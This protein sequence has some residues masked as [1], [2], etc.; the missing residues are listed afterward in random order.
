M[1][2]LPRRVGLARAK[3]LI[4]SGRAVATEEALRIGMVD[5][6]SRAETL[7][8]DAQAWA[9][10]LAQGTSTAIAL[11]KAILNKTYETTDE[12]VFALGSQAQGICYTTR[13]HQEAVAA[14]LN[15]RAS[16]TKDAP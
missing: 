15:R 4:F 2:F 6:L 12:Q 16:R 8:A 14:F 1:Y 10:E 3:E 9:E 7:L 13:E 5:R 11:S